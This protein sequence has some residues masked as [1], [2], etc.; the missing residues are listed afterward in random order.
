MGCGT[1][2]EGQVKGEGEQGQEEEGQSE[3]GGWGCGEDVD[4]KEY[5]GGKTDK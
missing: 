3:R 1:G 4:G 2:T 5:R